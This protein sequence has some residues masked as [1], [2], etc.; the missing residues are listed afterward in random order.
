MW[1]SGSAANITLSWSSR[2]RA[3]DHPGVGDLVGVRARRE[4]GRAGRA[5]GVQVARDVARSRRR[6]RRRR[7]RRRPSAPRGRRPRSPSSGS[8]AG[9]A[10]VTARSVAAPAAR[11]RPVSRATARACAHTIGSSSG[12]EAT[13]TRA[14]A[15]RTSSV[16]CSAA[17]PG[18]I[19]AKIPTA[20]AA[21]SSGSISPQLT[22][23]TA[24]ASPR[25]RPA[26]RARRR[27]VD[28]GG[29]L[30]ER[31]AY[32]RLPALG[33][34]QH[35]HRRCG[36]ARAR[37]R[38]SR[39]RRCWREARDRRAGPARPRRGRRGRRD[40]A[41]AGPPMAWV[42]AHHSSLHGRR[43]SVPDVRSAPS[44]RRGGRGRAGR[45]GSR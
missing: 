6:S 44:P 16:A 9:G 3:G 18:L 25:P 20:S 5:A 12:P 38:G 17:S 31:A 32:R 27:P 8:S 28:V 43:G 37:R 23:T 29:E 4:L 21:S 26:R 42:N 33:V 7:R 13:I 10:P 22:E 19:G 40:G 35:R 34:G 45:S 24:T 15:R 41:T 1:N 36:R 39:A 14:P 11:G 30:A 2:S